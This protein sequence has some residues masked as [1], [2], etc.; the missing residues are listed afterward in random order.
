MTASTLVCNGI[1]AQHAAD[2]ADQAIE[3]A[4]HGTD[5]ALVLLLQACQRHAFLGSEWKWFLG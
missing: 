4:D 5:D 1:A 3:Q 2:S